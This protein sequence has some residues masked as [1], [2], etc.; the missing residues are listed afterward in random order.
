MAERNSGQ[1]IGCLAEYEARRALAKE[2]SHMTLAALILALGLL[3]PGAGS[4]VSILAPVLL[5]EARTLRTD[6]VLGGAVAAHESA[7]RQ[8]AVGKR[9]E[10]G[11]MQVKPDG[12]ATRWCKAELKSLH[13]LRSNVRCGLKLLRHAMRVCSQQVGHA[14][15]PGKDLRLHVGNPGGATAC[16]DCLVR[17]QC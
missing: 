8:D 13:L 15:G 14:L 11:V 9:G 4:R 5:T 17:R 3:C 12:R 1:P 6:P 7:Y 16:F 10:L 2:E